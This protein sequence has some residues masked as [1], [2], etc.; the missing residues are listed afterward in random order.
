MKKLFLGLTLIVLTG[1]N[2]V[3]AAPWTA[4]AS[5]RCYVD[6]QLI[7]TGECCGGD[8]T[9]CSCWDKIGGLCS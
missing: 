5:C 2:F 4:G 6:G 7:C 1:L 9:Y 3:Y 8:G